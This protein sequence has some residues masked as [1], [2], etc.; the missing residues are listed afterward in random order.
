MDKRA[1]AA[2]AEARIDGGVRGR[3]M[4]IIAKELETQ[5]KELKKRASKKRRVSVG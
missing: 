2:Y 1:A 3:A 5:A 4:N